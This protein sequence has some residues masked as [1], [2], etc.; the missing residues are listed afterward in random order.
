MNYPDKIIISNFVVGGTA[1]GASID[2]TN[3]LTRSE[4]HYVVG[5]AFSSGASGD[6]VTDG[7]NVNGFSNWIIIKNRFND[8]TLSASYRYPSVSAVPYLTRQYFGGSVAAEIALGTTLYGATSNQVTAGTNAAL[9]NLN[10][11][12]HIVLR[13]VCREMD[14]ASNLRPDNTN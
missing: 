2:F 8:P 5:L 6:I 12:T 4:G 11:Q 7:Q 14:G 3:W 10:H 13:V 9:L 1:N